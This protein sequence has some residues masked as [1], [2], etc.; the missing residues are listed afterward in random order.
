LPLPVTNC[1]VDLGSA[2]IEADAV[3]HNAR[4]IAELDG[5]AYHR[6]PAAFERDRERDR[7]AVAAG[8]RVIRITWR[9]LEGDRRG[10]VRDLRRA[11]DPH[12]R[13]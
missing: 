11:L 8:W 13:E 3:W 2:F 6:T 9:Q 12:R 7:A 1:S 4:L 10:V 5:Y